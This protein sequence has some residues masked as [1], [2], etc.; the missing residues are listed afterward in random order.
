MTENDERQ[1][2]SK[3]EPPFEKAMARL[4]EI[5]AQLQREDVPLEKAFALW[6]EG[7][8]LHAHCSRILEGLK[9]RLEK[10]KAPETEG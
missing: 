5:V 1:I 3:E 9:E 4:E 6:E 7:Q 10:S 2:T 8:K